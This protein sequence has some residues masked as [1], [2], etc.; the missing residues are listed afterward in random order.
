M[1]S[2]KIRRGTSRTND[3]CRSRQCSLHPP[4]QIVG[5]ACGLVLSVYAKGHGFCDRCVAGKSRLPSSLAVKAP[6]SRPVSSCMR[7]HMIVICWHDW[8]VAQHVL[9][10]DTLPLDSLDGSSLCG[11]CMCVCVYVMARIRG[12]AAKLRWTAFVKAHTV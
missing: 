6:W 11:V 12:L 8:L 10:V 3:C 5:V 4:D 1:R 9:Y 7:V 2:W